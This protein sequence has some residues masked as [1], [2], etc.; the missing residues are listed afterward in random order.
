MAKIKVGFGD[1]ELEA[2]ESYGDLL[3]LTK[4]REF[5]AGWAYHKA[6]E[7]KFDIPDDNEDEYECDYEDYH[8]NDY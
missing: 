2:C 6:I 7:L 5:K 1:H 8:N 3:I 4:K